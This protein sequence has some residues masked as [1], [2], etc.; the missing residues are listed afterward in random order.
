[1]AGIDLKRA[2]QNEVGDRVQVY[3]GEQTYYYMVSQKMILKEKGESPHIR[4]ENAK[5]I[6]P[7]Q[8]ERLTMVTCWPYTNNT[9]RLVVVSSPAPPPRHGPHHP[10]L[11][12]LRMRENLSGE[13]FL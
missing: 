1:M 12:S 13:A 7:T 4:R 2:S 10:T 6:A 8:D 5:W 11:Q 3:V 9:H